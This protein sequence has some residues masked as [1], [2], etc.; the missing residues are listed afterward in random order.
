MTK[1]FSFSLMMDPLLGRV[2]IAVIRPCAC[3][4]YGVTC[5]SNEPVICSHAPPPHTEGTAVKMI[6]V[7]TNV[8]AV[9][10]FAL[11]IQN[12]SEMET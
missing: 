8:F 7:S 10:G 1:I 9:R 11:Y 6:R 3:L 12:G 5:S 4:S 2:S